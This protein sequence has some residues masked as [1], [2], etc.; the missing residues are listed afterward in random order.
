MREVEN[1]RTRRVF[2]WPKEAR[3][4]ARDYQDRMGKPQGSGEAGRTMLVTK[5]V[6]ISGNPRDACLRFLRQLGVTQR[7]NYRAW[8]KAEQQRLLDLTA[9]IPVEEAARIMRRPPGSVR[10]ML[11]R[12]E[13]GGR[14]GREWFTKSSLA[15]VLHIR[16]EEVQKWIDHGWLKCRIV[17]TVGVKRQIIDPDDFCEFFKQYGRQAAGR[18]LSYEGLSFV[19]NYVF[20]S[21]HAELLSLRESYKKRDA[22]VAQRPPSEPD[23]ASRDGE[24]EDRMDQSA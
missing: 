7:R 24:D 19:R 21:S 22:E 8:T 18:R 2:C 3:Q 9:S 14:R 5:L 6:Q 11:H 23:A 10:S 13:G 4:L 15:T 17:E 1:G 20:P 12:L 16:P